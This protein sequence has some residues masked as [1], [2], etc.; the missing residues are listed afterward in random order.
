M[1]PYVSPEAKDLMRKLLKVRIKFVCSHW[2]IV[3]DLLVIKFIFHMY[4]YVIYIFIYK[5]QKKRKLKLNLLNYA[6]YKIK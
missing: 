6:K 4:M 5:S 2:K 3:Y 1:P